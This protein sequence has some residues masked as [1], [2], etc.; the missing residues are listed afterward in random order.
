MKYTFRKF[1]LFT[2]IAF[3]TLTVFSQPVT[4]RF[5]GAFDYSANTISFKLHAVGTGT[6]AISVTEFFVRVPLAAPAFTWGTLTSNSTNFPGI[7]SFFLNPTPPPNDASYR[8]YH[9]IYT[10]P[11]PITTVANYTDNISYEILSVTTSVNPGLLNMEM[12]HSPVDEDPFYLAVTD[13]FG[14]DLRPLTENTFFYPTT[15]ISGDPYFLALSGTVPTSLKD[16]NVSKKGNSD[17]LLTWITSQEQDVSHFI[18]ERSYSQITGWSAIGQ[19]KAKGNSGTPTTYTFEDLNV[20]DGRAA[21][22]VVFYRIRAI[23]INASEKIFPIRSIKFSAFGAKEIS[24]YPNPANDGFVISIPIVN[25]GNNKIRLNMVN[26][27]GQVVHVRE[28][29]AANA[30]NYFYDLKTPG[31]ISGEYMLQIIYDGELLETKKVIV[32]H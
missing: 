17:A 18:L 15:D 21:S 28:I 6:A 22:K 29:S 8:Y 13:G 11:A 5:Q 3:C 23:D 27:L 7:G 30:T 12:I 2:V 10:A 26:R 19:V 32:Q 24:L 16:F 31:I 9:F 4:T 14:R 1:S 20:Y 25:P